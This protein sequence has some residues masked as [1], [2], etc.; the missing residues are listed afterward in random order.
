M[1]AKMYSA[2]THNIRVTV[3]P[4]FSDERSTPDLHRYFW[5]YA[6][7]ISNQGARKVQLLSRRWIITDALGHVETVE[8]PGVVGE[9]PT[10]APGVSFSYVSGCP[11]KTPSGSM[12]GAYRM[13]DESGALFEVEIPAFSLD[14][15]YMRRTLN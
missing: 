15:S 5:T 2:V 12:E 9:Q 7:E 6:V 4:D 1:S 14:S 8:G 11:L 10:L 3:R 13:I